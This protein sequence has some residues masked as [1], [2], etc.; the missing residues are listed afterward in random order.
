[1]DLSFCHIC[2][3]IALA[4]FLVCSCA[5]SLLAN[6]VPIRSTDA[7]PLVLF[8]AQSGKPSA[9]DVRL[10]LETAKK[11][12]YSEFMVYPRSGL[13]YEYMGEDWLDLV[14]NYLREAER[15]GMGIWLY[16][17]FNWP[18]GSCHGKVTED[19]PEFANTTCALYAKDDG[20]YDWRYFKAKATSAN[21]FDEDAMKRFRKLT[22]EVYERRFSRYFGTVI[23]GI[24]TD[25][26]G[27]EQWSATTDP[28]AEVEF[29]WYP[30]LER[31]YW[32]ETGRN[33]RTDVE[34][35]CRDNSKSTVWEDYTTV[36][37]HA[38]RRAFIDPITAWCDRLGIVSTGHLMNEAAP[39]TAAVSNGLTLH[40]LKG[41]SYPCV[42]E[43]FTHTTTEQAEWLTLATAQHAI[44]RR[45]NGGAAELFALGP[46]DLSFDRMRQMIW[47]AATHKIDTYF[48]SLHHQS[49]RG[50]IEKPHY[51]MFQS[52][53]QPW[54]Y[55]QSLFHET[56]REAARFAGKPFVCDVA[57]RYR[58]RLAGRIS[59][60]RD[61]DMPLV[62]LLRGLESRQFT[63]NLVEEDEMCEEPVVFDF[64][65]EGIV[66][67]GG[68]RFKDAAEALAFAG[69]CLPSKWRASE[70]GATASD[71]LMR[72][73]DDGSA[74]FLNLKEE[75]RALVFLKDGIE[76]PFMLPGR[77]VWIYRP[78]AEEW[79]LTIDRPNVRRI[80]FL[81]DGAAKLF[82][83][84]PVKVRFATCALPEASAK[85]TLD[86]FPLSG[87]K[88]CSFLGFG[89][90]KDYLETDPVELGA[91]EHVFT[92]EGREDRGLFLPV[93]WMEGKFAVVEPDRIIELP[94]VVGNGPLSE[95][96][97]ADFSGKVTYSADVA[98]PKDARYI[99]LGTGHAAASVRLAGHDL[100]TRLFS[101][102]R[103]EIPADLRGK[104]ETLEIT[105]TTS[106]RPMFGIE[107]DDI[108]GALPS[109][110]PD[111]V[112]TIPSEHDVGLVFTYWSN[113]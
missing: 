85:V 89:Y 29:R 41:L 91:G 73:Y 108:Q 112:K 94:D 100:G 11:A 87:S 86:G 23:R 27:S 110:K 76:I 46:S 84:K 96:A 6:P 19:H 92:C 16:D 65:G 31:D 83:E 101:P 88:E 70:L 61:G 74:V 102:W 33:F 14:G 42:D 49:A 9:A 24:F 12:G 52:P 22:H 1:M 54:F 18:S 35:Y 38:F 47:L 80:R 63:V 72:R 36:M 105:I 97:L 58:E 13:E 44:G 104:T 55:D 59:K 10:T 4:V 32:A 17:E 43:I 57:V 67:A 45:G 68:R 75:D 99:V 109:G 81:A 37:G 64:D 90:D 5:S 30:G 77:G 39:L 66:E 113:E 40:V 21:V 2:R 69:S 51:S 93:L 28:G 25:E 79:R 26:P 15:L 107:S 48:L 106:V 60:T 111:W 98:V 71:L 62:A 82:L 20:S 3:R 53:F 7:S 103:F 34:A 78:V 56:A 95:F 8:G 50:F